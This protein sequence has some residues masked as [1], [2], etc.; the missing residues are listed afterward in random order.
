MSGER[1]LGTA[2]GTG[3]RVYLSLP[4]GLGTVW[5]EKKSK[6]C[7]VGSSEAKWKEVG[8]SSQL[9]MDFSSSL[10]ILD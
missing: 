8:S 4:L 9:L 2:R 3:L 1:G 7:N 6:S 10:L 5:E